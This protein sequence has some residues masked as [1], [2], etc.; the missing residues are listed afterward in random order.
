M[1]G[2]KQATSSAFDVSGSLSMHSDGISGS[3][4]GRLGRALHTRSP[5]RTLTDGNNSWPSRP[6]KTGLHQS[7]NGCGTSG[8]ISNAIANAERL[9]PSGQENADSLL[10]QHSD[11]GKT[12]LM[13]SKFTFTCGSQV[14]GPASWHDNPP[15]G[16]SAECSRSEPLA[17]AAAS[18]RRIS[19]WLLTLADKPL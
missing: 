12:T 9:A 4:R 1:V 5:L 18:W 19:C 14:T 13:A 17:Y 3:G 10:R 8:I 16:G 6:P 7:D 15:A 11:S 2:G